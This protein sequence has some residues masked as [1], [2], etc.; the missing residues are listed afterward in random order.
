M[1][2]TTAPVS[3]PAA[4][5]ALLRWLPLLALLIA[6]AAI[7]LLVLGP[8]GWRAGWWHYRVGLQTLMPDAGYVGLAA[9]AVA[10]LALVLAVTRMIPRGSAV[11]AVIALLIGGAAAYF[12]W[13][14]NNQRGVYVTLND[15]TTDFADP[16]S[17][18]FAE[19]MRAAEHGNPVAYG[20]E[21]L[22]E[23]QKKAYPDI[24]SA[25]LNVP[26]AQAFERALAV[27]K[28]KGWT[29]VK[30]DPAAGI[31]DADE[32]SRWF[33]FTDDIAIRVTASGNGSRVDIRSGARQGRGDFGVNANRVRGFLE[34]LKA[35]G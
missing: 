21:T 18:A 17:L 29:I 7:V 4:G 27:A 33:G 8:L 11:L 22:V 32:K 1:T 2:E 12:P 5:R 25:M 16:P 10:L 14:W 13:H 30:T 19:Q 35:S 34:A 31:I 6:I 26:P 20:G 9:M 23:V 3:A 24:T 15:V 28:A